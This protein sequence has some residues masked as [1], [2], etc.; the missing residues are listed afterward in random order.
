[1][2]SYARHLSLS[3]VARICGVS[4]QAVR[5]WVH[6]EK[7]PAEETVLGYLVRLEDAEA[8]HSQRTARKAKGE[9]LSGAA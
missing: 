5:L 7:L 1:M 4:R 9:R 2:D 3:Q 8:L 6:A